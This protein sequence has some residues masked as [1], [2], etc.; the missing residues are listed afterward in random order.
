MVEAEL[1]CA[2]NI[3][4]P[5]AKHFSPTSNLNL[6]SFSLELI[7]YLI[8]TPHLIII[9][10]C[11]KTLSLFFVSPS[12]KPQWVC[13]LMNTKLCVS[14]IM[15]EFSAFLKAEVFIPLFVRKLIW[16]PVLSR[17]GSLG[18]GWW[19]QIQNS[20]ILFFS[21]PQHS[22]DLVQDK[23]VME[24]LKQYHDAAM[25]I[26]PWPLCM[27]KVILPLQKKKCQLPFLALARF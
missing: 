5:R 17:R 1:H 11:K 24:Q 22:Q 26:L 23:V 7:P 21:Q 14:N 10:P 20:K 9:C 4:V 13:A 2:S 18:Q 6:C 8:V 16:A 3:T 25:D 19:A 27:K 15:R 12:L